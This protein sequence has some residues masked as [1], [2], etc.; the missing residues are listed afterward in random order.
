[1]AFI[2]QPTGKRKNEVTSGAVTDEDDL[3]LRVVGFLV[4]P[5][6]MGVDC[7]GVDDD[8]RERSVL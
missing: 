2:P 5:H 8:C 4:A 7:G 6:D 3:P 1:M